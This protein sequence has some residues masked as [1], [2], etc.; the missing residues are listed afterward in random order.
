M[1]NV[2]VSGSSDPDDYVY[3]LAG[4]QEI[5]NGMERDRREHSA[6][7]EIAADVTEND[8]WLYGQLIAAVDEVKDVEKQ[9]QRRNDILLAVGG[10]VAY[11]GFIYV[12]FKYSGRD[13]NR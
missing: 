10:C 11:A 6:N 12:G 7:L 9:R 3:A 2:E 13:D 1:S 4:L 8:P 5:A